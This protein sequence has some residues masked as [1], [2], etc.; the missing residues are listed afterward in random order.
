LREHA[1]SE[2]TLVPTFL[3]SV[4]PPQSV[5][6]IEHPAPRM[7]LRERLDQLVAACQA[8]RY[9][10]L[11]IAVEI[12][13]YRVDGETNS[14]EGRTNF[15]SRVAHILGAG[16]DS[17]IALTLFGWI[18]I[19]D[20]LSTNMD[21]TF[22]KVTVGC[23]ICLAWMDL[24]TLEKSAPPSTPDKVQ[25]IIESDDDD[26]SDETTFPPAPKRQ[27]PNRI[28]NPPNP[29]TAHRHYCPFVCGFPTDTSTRDTPVWRGIVAR[30][31]Q[32]A[33]ATEGDQVF[34]AT[35]DGDQAISRIRKILRSGIKKGPAI[36][37][38][39]K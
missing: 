25:I 28:H 15:L 27:R 2:M 3:A 35:T 31:F 33:R 24:E 5:E 29:L 23:P 34:D 9:P 4:L 37:E 19:D 10:E 30:L 38:E 18:P 26:S 21:S 1:V 17:I 11:E 12:I 36:L 14:R 20:H 8:W 13:N 22:P 7:L 39:E 6:L 32:E 16:Y